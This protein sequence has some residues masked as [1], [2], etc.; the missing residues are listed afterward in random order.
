MKHLASILS[1]NQQAQAPCL[2]DALIAARQ[3][4]GFIKLEL[5]W[6]DWEYRM[7]IFFRNT[8]GSSIFARGKDTDPVIAVKLAMDQVKKCM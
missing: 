1:F 2:E 4:K 8:Q 3:V 5:E 7:E 6:R